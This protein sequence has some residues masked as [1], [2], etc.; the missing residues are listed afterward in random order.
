MPQKK[1]MFLSKNDQML[2]QLLQEKH[3]REISEF[4]RGVEESHG[5]EQGDIGTKYIIG[6][7]GELTEIPDDEEPTKLRSA[8]GV[9]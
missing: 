5:L 6:Q 3:A 8:E 1:K 2:L 7:N 9:G 4:A